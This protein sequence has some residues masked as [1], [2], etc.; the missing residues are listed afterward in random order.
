MP[1]PRFTV[2]SHPSS[3]VPA[4][5]RRHLPD[6][7]PAPRRMVRPRADRRGGHRAD[8][9]GARP[10]SARRARL[11]TRAG[12]LEAS[13]AA[14]ARRGPAR[15]PAR[16]SAT[17]ATCTLVELPRGDFARHDAAQL[18]MATLLELLWE[19]LARIERRRAGRDRRQGGEGGAL[20]PA[21]CRRL[22]GAPR[23]RHRRIGA[24]HE[25][26]ARRALAVHRRDVRG[27][28][29]R[30]RGRRRRPRPALVRPARRLARRVRR[31][32]RRG[33][34]SRCRP[35]ARSA[36][37]ARSAGT[38]STWA[39][40]W[41][42][43]S[44]CSA[45]T[46]AGCGDDRAVVRSRSTR[47]GR[48]RL[49]RAR[50]VS[51]IPRCRSSRCVDLGI[52][53]DVID[54]G[55]CARC[56]A[57]A[58]LL[59]LPGDRG[60]RGEHRRRARRRRARPGARSRMQRAPAWT[61]DW[62]SADGRAQ[63]ARLRHRAARSGRSREAACAAALRA[64]RRRAARLPALRQRRHRAPVRLRRDRVQGAVALPRLPRAVRALQA[65]LTPA[66]SRRS[67]PSEGP[68]GLRAPCASRYEPPLHPTRPRRHET[69][70]VV[71][72]DVPGRAR[73]RFRFTQ[74]QH[75]TLRTSV[76][77]R[78]CA[79]RTRSA[80]ASTT[81]SCA[82]ACARCRAACSRPGSTSR[83][84]P[85]DTLAGDDAGGALLRSARRP[86][87]ARHYLGI[88][89]GSGITPILSIM[90]TVLGARAASRASR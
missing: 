90:K 4:A 70:I 23:R 55:R 73:E 53:R 14:R 45:P 13:S 6:P 47:G 83:S 50:A 86:S 85:G 30:R 31:R 27:R 61:T 29:G 20:P 63:A 89:G 66:R 62:I 38:A 80:P 28:R 25:G 35:S 26:R 43:C 18:A 84:K 67:L 87:A 56:R 69:P 19:R 32:A 75:L 81:A 22:G 44:T 64:A 15:L 39:T 36:A 49:G 42:R 60:D 57:H 9:H 51:S 77:G 17:T 48:A 58:D 10:R 74:G 34:R 52:V 12:E 46:R 68:S 11:L 8:Q 40:C 21:A 7:R 79:A 33:R 3:A 5:H 72:F 2:S 78:T 24:P 88:A 1:A 65:D 71:S 59:G 76:D 82:S 41:P 37:P 16:A 54:D